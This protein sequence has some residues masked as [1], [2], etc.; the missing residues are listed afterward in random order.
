[1]AIYKI[2]Y[3][4]I[5]NKNRRIDGRHYPTKVGRPNLTLRFSTFGGVIRTD[6]SSCFLYEA[7]STEDEVHDLCE[8]TGLTELEGI[9]TE[10]DVNEYNLYLEKAGIDKQF[11][12]A[13]SASTKTVA[14]AKQ[15]TP[16]DTS[17]GLFGKKK[18]SS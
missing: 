13:S 7:D 2:R 14:P 1:M 15:K 6:G 11:T 8:G 9:A 16:A 17:K 12:Y 3:R 5:S 18:K 4:T 10:E